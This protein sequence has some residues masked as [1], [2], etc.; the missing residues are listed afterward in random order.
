MTH[1]LRRSA[2]RMLGRALVA[3]AATATTAL[4]CSSASA[5]VY[6]DRS[7]FVAALTALGFSTGT[8]DFESH[9]LGTLTSGQTLGS[10]QYLFDASVTVAAI[11]SDGAGGTALGGSPSDVFVGGDAVDLAFNGT[12]P[13]LAFG[14]DF[15]YA[16]SFDSVPASTYRVTVQDGTAAGAA[17]GN[18]AGLDAA[19]GSF[20]LGVIEDPPAA[21]RDVRLASLVPVDS[22]GDPLFLAPAYQI[23][24]LVF[25]STPA[26]PEPG[27]AL[28]SLFG[29]GAVALC[30]RRRA[31]RA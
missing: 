25:A 29:V 5:T 12:R 21:F 7:A 27:T 19:G 8:E 2:R 11:A 9:P 18:D 6:H 24:N 20:F 4:T 14:A 13:L 26:V 10:F 15:F 23:D 17:V 22:S 3:A 28:L 31:K 16:P 1:T 30:G